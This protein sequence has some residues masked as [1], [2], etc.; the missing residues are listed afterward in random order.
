MIFESWVLR[1]FGHT[2]IKEEM[3]GVWRELY[4]YDEGHYSLFASS[5]I[6]RWIRW[7]GNIACIREMINDYQ[8]NKRLMGKTWPWMELDSM[9]VR[10][11]FTLILASKFID[12]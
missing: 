3:A 2:S 9:C 6:I 12:I 4:T 1:M 8:E 5:D 7:I 10:F 11:Y